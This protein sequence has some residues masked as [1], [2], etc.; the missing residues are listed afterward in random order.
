MKP[1][2]FLSDLFSLSD[3][4]LSVFL[5]DSVSC[6]G[7]S[8]DCIRCGSSRIC[9][10]RRSRRNSGTDC[11]PD[12]RASSG[13]WPWCFLLRRE[14]AAGEMLL[15]NP[16]RKK[17]NCR[18]LLQ[19]LAADN[20]L[21][22]CSSFFYCRCKVNKKRGNSITYFSPLFYLIPQYWVKRRF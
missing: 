9:R 2:V 20:L 22:C 8:A 17:P 19:S 6:S 11:R 16:G 18:L 10:T 13:N 21:V 5:Y 15:H 3:S 1:I 7:S 12:R 4:S 14:I